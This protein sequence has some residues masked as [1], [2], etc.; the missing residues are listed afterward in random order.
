MRRFEY[1]DGNSRK[2]WEIDL[3]GRT[4]S[5]RFGRLRT[6]GASQVKDLG[7]TG[8]AQ[9]HHDRMIAAKLKKG[10]TEAGNANNEPRKP[11]VIVPQDGITV[12]RGMK[13]YMSENSS[14][15][16]RIVVR[17]ADDVD[18]AFDA[19]RRFREDLW[20]S[21]VFASLDGEFGNDVDGKP[22]RYTP[23]YASD[24]EIGEEGPEFW[25]DAQDVLETWPELVDGAIH[26]LKVRLR[27]A[28]V[29]RAEIGKPRPPYAERAYVPDADWFH[30]QGSELTPLDEIWLPPNFPDGFPVPPKAPVVVA[31]RARDETWTSVAWRRRKA[32]DEF[33]DALELWR[34]YGLAIRPMTEAPHGPPD[35]SW[36]WNQVHRAFI[37]HGRGSHGWA[38]IV[39]STSRRA[40]DLHVVWFDPDPR[41]QREAP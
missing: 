30:M 22:L 8:A 17:K 32:Q 34:E 2:F 28:G 29:Q 13:T 39:F 18:A 37:L 6:Q 7:S 9:A 11:P 5:V 1:D 23:S 27:E 16:C 10:Y 12:Q 3:E 38:W 4:V 20:S 36:G 19:I 21:D 24:V 40:T 15:A 31:H 14:C 35:I 25:F 33:Q 26:Q 41:A